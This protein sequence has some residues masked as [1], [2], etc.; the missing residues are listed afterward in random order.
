MSKKTSSCGNVS[1]IMKRGLTTSVSSRSIFRLRLFACF[2]SNTSVA[3]GLA[4]DH[5]TPVRTRGSIIHYPAYKLCGVFAERYSRHD[6]DDISSTV[7]VLAGM[8]LVPMTWFVTTVAADYFLGWKS[9]VLSLPLVVI[10]GYA[11]LYTLEETAEL[12]GWAKAVLLFFTRR[13]VFLRLYV[14]RRDL[15][16][17]L[18]DFD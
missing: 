8:V 12:R 9:A 17:G 10:C 15:M 7:K 16:Q 4:T 2:C 18:R 5:F 1:L 14:E 11:A 3:A 13:D 6:A